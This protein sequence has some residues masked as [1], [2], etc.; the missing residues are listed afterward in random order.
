[1]LRL[2]HFWTNNVFWIEDIFLSVTYILLASYPDMGLNRPIWLFYMKSSLMRWWW[3]GRGAYPGPREAG[4]P[5]RS[6][7]PGWSACTWRGSCI[8]PSATTGRSCWFWALRHG[9]RCP[10]WSFA[11]LKAA[12]VEDSRINSRLQRVGLMGGYWLNV[13]HKMV[14][15]VT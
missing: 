3:W 11:Q 5:S 2:L 14:Y 15:F 7:S 13:S 12:S 10:C 6:R 4:S 1:M 8:P 9:K